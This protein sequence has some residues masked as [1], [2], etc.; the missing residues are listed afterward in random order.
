M[1]LQHSP[2]P[3]ES[4]F[5]SCPPS[6]E[7]GTAPLP[8]RTAIGQ[9]GAARGTCTISLSLR[10]AGAQALKIRWESIGPVDAP[11]ILV[12]GGISANRHVCAST[13]FPESGWWQAQA[14]DGG[15]LDT[16]RYRLL[17]IDWLGADGGLDVCID[18]AD[19]ADAIAA[20][21]DQLQIE[22][23]A[24]FVGASY[25]AMVGLQFAAR[26]PQRLR[27]L[28][29]ISGAHRTHAQTTA[30]R[31]IQRRIVKL[32]VD[33][34]AANEALALARALA[35]IGYRSPN[36]FQQR[37][38]AQPSIR[39]NAPHFP[40]EDYLDAVGSKF[41]SRFSTTAYLR[42]SESIDFQQVQPESI[43]VPTDVVAI[44]QDQIV[45]LADLEELTAR[46]AGR[47][48]LHRISSLYGHDAF[49]K[50]VDAI[51]AILHRVL[52]RPLNALPAREA[53]V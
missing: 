33:H 26:H 47:R 53:L 24:A 8:Y 25:G 10:H 9:T 46:L 50:E 20:V 34:S 14:G 1:S 37:F 43:T 41:V 18:P 16:R 12:Q 5:A 23:V 6:T 52:D 21:L 48:L 35:V 44:D 3:T 19:Q 42:L 40:V 13:Q 28:I 31:V 38:A 39:D 32:G 4:S 2:T 51:A 27:Q 29:A 7:F 45:P 30:L 17:A 22:C 36:E 15:P 49:L 11:V